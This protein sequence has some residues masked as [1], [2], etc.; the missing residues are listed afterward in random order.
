MFEH[1]Y[2]QVNKRII[3]SR[4]HCSSH[5]THRKSGFYLLLKSSIENDLPIHVFFGIS[6][7]KIC[8]TTKTPQTSS[9]PCLIYFF[10][11]YRSQRLW[12]MIMFFP[13]IHHFDLSCSYLPHLGPYLQVYSA[14]V[15]I[16]RF[17]NLIY[18]MFESL[19]HLAISIYL[20]KSKLCLYH[21]FA[22]QLG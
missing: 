14:W 2:K 9:C 15:G 12:S 6:T 20:L 10:L 19:I 3:L 13:V 5:H 8:K 17:A 11:S 4:F 1:F 7:L 22:F 18:F 16:P 21:C